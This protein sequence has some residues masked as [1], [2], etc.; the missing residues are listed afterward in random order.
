VIVVGEKG[1]KA[2]AGDERWL[3]RYHGSIKLRV[4]VV[5]VVVSCVVE[6]L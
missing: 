3:Y 2:L 1:W 4:V 6:G 5:V